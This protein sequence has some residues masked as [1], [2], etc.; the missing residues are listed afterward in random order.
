MDPE[1]VRDDLVTMLTTTRTAERKLFERLDPAVRDAPQ[2]AGEWS[3]KDIQAHLSGWKARQVKRYEAARN[4]QGPDTPD[5]REIDEVNAEMH[6]ARA[7]A[8]P[9]VALRALEN[10]E[11]L[12]R[13]RRYSAATAIGER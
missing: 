9:A 3:P 11:G 1:R 10:D 12:N 8:R 6:E 7:G 4:G 13:S 2:A 5:A